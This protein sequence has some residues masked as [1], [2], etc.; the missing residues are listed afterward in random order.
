MILNAWGVSFCAFV[1]RDIS[2]ETGMVPAARTAWGGGTSSSEKKGE[3]PISSI[4]TRTA[5]P[6][7]P[8]S[9]GNGPGGET[10]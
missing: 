8:V 9:S 4:K 2:E 10:M 5:N 1:K 6:P 3:H 7:Q